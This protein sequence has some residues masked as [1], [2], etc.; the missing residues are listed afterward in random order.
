MNLVTGEDLYD[1]V[2]IEDAINEIKLIID[3]GKINKLY[4]IGTENPK[5]LKELIL[6]SKKRLNSSSKINF[7]VFNDDTFIDFTKFDFRNTFDELGYSTK[8]SLS[9]A[10]TKY[11]KWVKENLL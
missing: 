7:G 10:I 4:Y 8:Y 6:I 3:N 11:S 1:W 2:Y 5:T 9:E